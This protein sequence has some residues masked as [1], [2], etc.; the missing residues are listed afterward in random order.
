MVY[1]YSGYFVSEGPYL[2]H[3]GVLGM[4]WGVRRYRNA[5]GTYT[6]AGKKRHAD[7][8]ARYEGSVTGRTTERKYT[9][10]VKAS[11]ASSSTK[12]SSGTKSKKNSRIKNAVTKY[13]NKRADKGEYL[14]TEKHKSLVKNHIKMVGNNVAN[15]YVKR[16]ARLLT[17]G[18]AVKV[19]DNY[20]PLSD[21][22]G[23]SIW[24]AGKLYDAH[25]ADQNK[26]IALYYARKYK[27]KRD[28]AKKEG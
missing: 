25:L 14:V 2:M 26:D 13:L 6:A 5:D 1:C 12:T 9:R 4:K 18:R 11:E 22:V 24:A 16:G 3:Y 20:I 8:Q 21:V 28:A 15:R 17:M 7:Q 19:G 10:T 23:K 27:R